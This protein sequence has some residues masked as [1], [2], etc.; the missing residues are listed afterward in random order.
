MRLPVVRLEYFSPTL[1]WWLCKKLRGHRVIKTE[2]CF[3]TGWVMHSC[4]CG[5]VW[6]EKTK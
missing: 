5:W 2:D 1:L 3:S 4:R 6:T